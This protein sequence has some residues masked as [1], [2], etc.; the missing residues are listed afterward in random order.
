MAEKLRLQPGHGASL[1]TA[2]SSCPNWLSQGGLQ[3]PL[4]T[5]GSL[6]APPPLCPPPHFLH[7]VWGMLEALLQGTPL[8]STPCSPGQKGWIRIRK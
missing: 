8:K 7:P 3:A 6:I 2:S 5:T 4:R 1:P